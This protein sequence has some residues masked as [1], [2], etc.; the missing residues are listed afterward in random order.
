MSPLA[1]SWRGAARQKTPVHLA[2]PLLA[3]Q[4]W[5]WL[6]GLFGLQ[7][8]CPPITVFGSLYGLAAGYI[9]ARTGSTLNTFIMYVL[10]DGLLLMVALRQAAIYGGT[11]WG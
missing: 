11:K 4:A 7:H 2:P 1:S 8:F 3:G 10:T 6:R 9:R 5:C